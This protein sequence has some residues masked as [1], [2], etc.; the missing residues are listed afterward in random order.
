MKGLLIVLIPSAPRQ[1][2][3]RMSK[4]FFI[5][6]MLMGGIHLNYAQQKAPATI[7]LQNKAPLRPNPYLPLPLGSIKPKGWLLTQFV[8]MKNGMSGQ[9]DSLYPSV[10]G[11]RNGWL[12]GDGDVWERGP[13]NQIKQLPQTP[14]GHYSWWGSQRGAD[15][16]LTKPVKRKALNEKLQ[17][18]IY[19]Q[20]SIN[21][22]V[23]LYLNCM[24][25][26]C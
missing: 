22:I 10:L 12:G 21:K 15:L 26:G 24:C 11:P 9:L 20:T 18:M 3:Y 1:R 2:P 6:L 16:W 19:R 4:R 5:I 7:L 13:Y 25:Y 23:Y 14:L 8:T 17:L